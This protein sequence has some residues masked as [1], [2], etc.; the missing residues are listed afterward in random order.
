MSTQET[1][2]G[3]L[4]LKLNIPKWDTLLTAIKPID[5]WTKL[6]G[7]GLELEPHVTILYG[8]KNSVSPLDI[9]DCVYAIKNPI[10]VKL[11]SIS[12]FEAPTFDVLKF[13]VDSDKLHKLHKIFL[14]FPNEQTYPIYSP[15]IT[16]AY[17]KKGVGK[18]YQRILENPI[19]T[20]SNTFI[21]S[22]SNGK[23]YIWKNDKVI[24]IRNHDKF[25]SLPGGRI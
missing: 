7:F 6:P 23:K 8:F 1:K 18:S 3:C 21:Y 4:M 22:E 10:E 9:K 19:R 11:K 17:V 15:H 5:L 2:Y 24:P 20:K 25:Y 16:V 13:D 14:K 12:F